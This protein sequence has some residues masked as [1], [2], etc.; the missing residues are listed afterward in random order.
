MKSLFIIKPNGRRFRN[1]LT[2]AADDPNVGEMFLD[3]L[4]PAQTKRVKYCILE[5]SFKSAI[6][7]AFTWGDT[8]EKDKFWREI[9]NNIKD[10]KPNPEGAKNDRSNKSI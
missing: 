7:C 6:I 9:Y 8:K 2:K 3:N 5:G 1:A 4:D 10:Y